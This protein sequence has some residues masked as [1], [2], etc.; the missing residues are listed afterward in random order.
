MA[1][2]LTHTPPTPPGTWVS[3]GVS[4]S[5]GISAKL[6][7]MQLSR[8][9]FSD[10]LLLLYLGNSIQMQIGLNPINPFNHVCASVCASVYV[11]AH[12]FVNIHHPCICTYLSAPWSI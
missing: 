6:L 3:P 1:A 2:S 9:V 12:S 7:Q 8:Q 10:L 11:C 5:V 4:G